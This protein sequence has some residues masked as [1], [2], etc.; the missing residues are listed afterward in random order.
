M[1]DGEYDLSCD[2]A[3]PWRSQVPGP[4]SV[5]LVTENPIRV[6]DQALMTVNTT[7]NTSRKLIQQ[8][9]HPSL[10]ITRPRS[11]SFGNT[12]RFANN[13]TEGGPP[14]SISQATSVSDDNNNPPP[15]WQR[16]P[17]QRNQKRKKFTNSPPYTKNMGG[18]EQ[19]ITNI[20][21]RY[22]VL[23]IDSIE[24]YPVNYQILTK[25]YINRH[26]LSYME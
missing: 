18:N 17:T 23:P 2:P 21:N 6:G 3:N 20:S 25:K 9:F 7:G 12:P 8:A 11:N 14:D 1:S 26:Q 4:A 10:F 13:L 15:P 5:K 22:S 19:K 24:D 16:V